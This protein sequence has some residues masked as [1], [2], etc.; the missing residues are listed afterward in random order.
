MLSNCWVRPLVAHV[1]HLPLALT[2]YN[3]LLKLAPLACVT[4]REQYRIIWILHIIGNNTSCL[5]SIVDLTIDLSPVY[6]TCIR[7]VKVTVAETSYY[8]REKQQYE[9]PKMK[10]RVKCFG[11][12]W[13][14]SVM[15][16]LYWGVNIGRN[17]LGTLLGKV[18]EDRWPWKGSWSL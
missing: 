9:G 16:L 6:L 17:H 4:Q 1:N 3:Y 10:R 14:G 8:C 12:W 15:W 5:K 18:N 7:W 11:S 13:Y 2:S